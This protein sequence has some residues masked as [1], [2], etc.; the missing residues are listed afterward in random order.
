MAGVKRILFISR[1]DG[2]SP[3]EFK[4]YYESKHIPLVESLVPMN[5]VTSYTRNF[6]D[7]PKTYPRDTKVDFDVIT[8]MSWASEE[9]YKAYIKVMFSK[10]V[11]EK[12]NVD[13][14]KFQA[15][16]SIR[17]FVV[18]EQKSKLPTK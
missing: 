12:L 15:P 13:E 4:E 8:E 9:D 10:E 18:T 16:G 1:K 14:A 6:V 3:D 17:T 7:V 2:M 11:M 5:L